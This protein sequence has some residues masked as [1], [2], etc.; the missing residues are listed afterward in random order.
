[1]QVE[2]NCPVC[3]FHQIERGNNVCPRCRTDL[4]LWN[5]VIELPDKC[6]NQALQM[7][8]ATR[9]QEAKEK[10]TAA[11]GLYPEHLGSRVLLG[12]IYA[13]L[14][15]FDAAI[16]AWE[17]ALKQNPEN[18]REIEGLIT[19]A[20]KRQSEIV[21]RKDEEQKRLLK[22]VQGEKNS[23]LQFRWI[24]YSAL[25]SVVALIIG[26]FIPFHYPF[27]A[28]A[29]ISSVPASKPIEH[30]QE[31][32]GLLN[33]GIQVKQ[34][35]SIVGEVM[36]PRESAPASKPIECKQEVE[37]MLKAKDISGIKVN[38]KK[39]IVYLSGEVI[40]PQEKY[41]LEKL[42]RGIKGVSAV[43]LTGIEVIHPQGYY[44]IVRKGDSLW[45]IAER[46]LGDGSKYGIIY[47]TNKQKIPLLSNISPGI[48][49]VIPE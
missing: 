43:D 40:V 8:R 31:V 2:T 29:P 18:P 5:E 17:M 1:M 25:F 6:Y 23:R 3:D 34:K 32:E 9:L 15:M 19:K 28:L 49:I 21:S 42:I 22:N 33:S 37:E 47:Q 35:N 30:K 16:A 46:L 38:Q 24:A 11:L 45:S 48:T 27:Q 13:E 10:L 41:Q 39:S 44:Y 7:I 12:K 20:K 26:I 4:S 36:V 14:E